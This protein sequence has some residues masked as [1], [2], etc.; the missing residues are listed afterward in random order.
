MAIARS[1]KGYSP[2]R[3]VCVLAAIEIRYNCEQRGTYHKAAVM[4]VL[5]FEF[6]AAYFGVGMSMQVMCVFENG[7]EA[8]TD[9]LICWF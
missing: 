6:T 2:L 4:I 3:K 1:N 9:N 8:N 5:L 7:R